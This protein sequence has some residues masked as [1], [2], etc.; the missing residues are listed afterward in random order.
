M[1]DKIVHDFELNNRVSSIHKYLY[2]KIIDRDSKILSGIP[3][4]EKEIDKAIIEKF[5]FTHMV[6]KHLKDIFLKEMEIYGLIKRINRNK[7][8]IIIN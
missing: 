5:L 3:K 1:L 8:K 4:H 7:I 2:D 6:P